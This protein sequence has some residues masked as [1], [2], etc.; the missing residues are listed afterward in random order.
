M[1]HEE[2]PKINSK[3][4]LEKAT[5]ERVAVNS[6]IQVLQQVMKVGMINVA[7]ALKKTI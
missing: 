6:I 1:G 3:N 4:R 7:K 5:S 2:I